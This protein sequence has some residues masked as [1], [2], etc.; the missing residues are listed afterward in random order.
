[1]CLRGIYI[2]HAP[3]FTRPPHA[4]THRANLETSAH[5]DETSVLIT[6]R[7]SNCLFLSFYKYCFCNVH[8]L[9]NISN[10]VLFSNSTEDDTDLPFHVYFLLRFRYCYYPFNWDTCPA[11]VDFREL[12]TQ[13]IFSILYVSP[14]HFDQIRTFIFFL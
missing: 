6:L 2:A 14:T 7:F 5:S 3:S 8:I 13:F 9:P 1:M 10:Q 4:H 11:V 12:S